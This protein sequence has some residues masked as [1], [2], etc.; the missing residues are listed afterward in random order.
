L[1]S[2]AKPGGICVSA[3][4]RE[5]V[6]ERLAL[7]FVDTGEQT[8]KNIEKPVRVFHVAF[9]TVSPSPAPRPERSK[10][11]IAVL[12]FTNMSGDPEQEYFA[13]GITE[14][15]ITDLS[16]VS[17]LSV[18]A[19]NSMFT[20]K[21]QSADVQEVGRRFNAT[22]VLEGSVRKAGNRVRINAQLIGAREGTH[23]WADR[24]DR[25]LTDTISLARL[26]IFADVSRSPA[27]RAA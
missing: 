6:G 4:V 26:Y 24:Y 23:L 18:I 7:R 8:L 15:I 12:P 19:R 20:Y 11:S 25:D 1:E 13:D 10:P 22:N 3:S 17:G 27:S 9:D 2:I 21:G 5:Q 16:K 14:D